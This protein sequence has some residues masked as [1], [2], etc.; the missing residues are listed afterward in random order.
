VVIRSPCPNRD[1]PEF[2]DPDVFD[3]VRTRTRTSPSARR[4]L[5]P[6]RAVGAVGGRVALNILLDRF[7][8]LHTDPAEAPVFIPS[9]NMT[10]VRKLPLLLG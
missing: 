4:A 2:T 3:P 7:P 5:L 9:V 6:R 8:D 10:G 1:E